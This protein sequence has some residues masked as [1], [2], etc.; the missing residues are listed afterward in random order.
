MKEPTIVK[1]LYQTVMGDAEGAAY[2]PQLILRDAL[3]PELLGDDHGAINYW[4]GKSLAR[5]FP[6][7]N[8]KDASIFFEQAGFGTLT[9]LKQTDHVSEWQLSGEPVKLR[10]RLNA[11]E[12][13]TLEA[14]FLA[15]M[16]AQQL[17]VETE[18]ELADAPRK[19]RDQAVVFNVYTDPSDVIPDYDAPEPL[20]I[21]HPDED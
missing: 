13:F 6:L 5:R 9:L 10:K 16:M 17:G 15:E 2:L 7:G 3:L 1:N 4:A 21:V 14:G 19:L 11:E 12:G 20:K 8:P 18:S